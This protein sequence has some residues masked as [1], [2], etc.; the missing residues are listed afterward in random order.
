MK[1]CVVVGKP[2]VGKTLLVLRLAESSRARTVDI[3]F[4]EPDGARHSRT[5]AIQDALRELVGREPH[6]TRR[7]Q[8]LVMALPAG[9]GSGIVELVDTTGLTD[10]I[11]ED[12]AVRKAMAQTLAV[13]RRAAV[14]VHV[15][16][17]AAIGADGSDS[18]VSEL[19]RELARYA[20]SRG[21][22]FMVA[23]KMDLPGAERGLARLQRFFAGRAIPIVAASAATRAGLREVRRHVVRRL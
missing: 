21:G 10:S 14:V 19:D 6:Q 3:C 17:A 22:Y 11:H 8:S 18:P 9:K 4:H 5:Y 23:N 1:R 7:L 15:V 2:S 16:D 20:S 12:A 13:V